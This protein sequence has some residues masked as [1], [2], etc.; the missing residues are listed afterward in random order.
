[1]TRRV[2]QGF[3]CDVM[4]I[5]NSPPSSPPHKNM[6]VS[7]TGWAL[8]CICT[9]SGD[10]CWESFRLKP[11][12]VI[13]EPEIQMAHVGQPN[14]FPVLQRC[15]QNTGRDEHTRRHIVSE[16][17][18]KV[19]EKEAK[20]VNTV[21]STRR[22]LCASQWNHWASLRTAGCKIIIVSDTCSFTFNLTVDW[23]LIHSPDWTDVYVC[24]LIHCPVTNTLV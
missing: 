1:M 13:K 10:A 18:P 9:R 14:H 17:L 15:I 22:T 16:K 6:R 11:V 7:N 3:V 12:G 23:I 2:T 8:G 4:F 20:D 5:Y 21:W 19:T 24:V